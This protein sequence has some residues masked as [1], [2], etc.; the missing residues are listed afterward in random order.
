MK[1]LV[2]ILA[3]SILHKLSKIQILD[4]LL[5]NLFVGIYNFCYSTEGVVFYLD[6]KPSLTFQSKVVDS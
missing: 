3:F 6:T 2:T 5:K 4:R 1:V